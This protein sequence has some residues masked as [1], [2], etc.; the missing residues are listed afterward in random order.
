MAYHERKI[1]NQKTLKV[2][3]LKIINRMLLVIVI[4]VIN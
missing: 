4:Y 1:Q 3:L 2:K